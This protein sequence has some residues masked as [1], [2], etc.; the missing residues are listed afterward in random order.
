MPPDG[1][2]AS[3]NL[4]ILVLAASLL[5]DAGTEISRLITG[6]IADK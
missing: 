3:G 2:G 1:K 6:S 5:G 4:S